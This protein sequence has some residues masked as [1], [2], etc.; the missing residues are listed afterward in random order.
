M[1]TNFS[2]MYDKV[3]GNFQLYKNLV[4]FLN[5]KKTAFFSEW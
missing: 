2:G 4:F 1:V 3:S 5:S